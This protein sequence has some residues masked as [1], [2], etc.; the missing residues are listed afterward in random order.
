[1]K[2]PVA[3]FQSPHKGALLETF[4][5]NELATLCDEQYFYTLSYFRT[6]EGQE[7]DFVVSNGEKHLLIECKSQ[8]PSTQESFK[9]IEYFRKSYP[10]A[11]AWILY[12][13]EELKYLGNN[14]YGVPLSFLAL[15]FD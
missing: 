12:P 1:L 9:G 13:G 5:F 2:D 7:V 4:V 3:L 14:I 11:Q 6:L 8:L 10:Q 15:R